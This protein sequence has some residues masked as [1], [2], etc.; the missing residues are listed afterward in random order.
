[1]KVELSPVT[2]L[3][4]RVGACISCEVLR[5]VKFT[6]SGTTMNLHRVLFLLAVTSTIGYGQLSYSSFSGFTISRSAL[7]FGAGEQGVALDG[8]LATMQYN[9][10]AIASL[11]I[12]SF[13]SGKRDAFIID[14]AYALSW[15]RFGFH[16]N[17]IGTFALEYSQFDLGEVVF[18]T[19]ADNPDGYISSTIHAI[20]H[21]YALSYA[22]SITR[23]IT[24]GGTIRYIHS[25]FYRTVDHIF[26]SGGVLYQPEILNKQLSIGF[27]LT[28]FGT[29]IHYSDADQ[30]DPAPAYMRLGVAASPVS[31]DNQKLT[32]LFE[33]SRLIA[34]I[35][36]N[37]DGKS[38]FSALFSSFKYWPHDI[39]GHGGLIYSFTDIALTGSLHFH[40]Q[41]AFGVSDQTMNSFR[42]N[43]MTASWA[44]GFTAGRFTLD[45]GAASVWQYISGN[46][47]D[48]FFQKTIPDEELELKIS[49]SPAMV[50]PES[51]ED[52][53]T[54]L[55]AGI[56]ALSP[57]GHLKEYYA[58]NGIAYSIELAHYT[59]PSTAIVSSLS[60]EDN[61]TGGLMNMFDADG[62]WRTFMVSMMYRHDF[63][64]QWFPIYFQAGPSLFRWS[65]IP[66]SSYLQVS[67]RYKYFGGITAG[68]GIPIVFNKI[69]IVPNLNFISM[70]ADVSGSAPR[71]GGYNQWSFCIRLG[72]E[73]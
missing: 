4:W 8:G 12:F 1:M 18:T 40:Q 44:M 36:D 9:P 70:F 64:A 23:S 52:N 54:T 62:K 32:F 49:Y 28:D 66:S 41:L 38:S 24:L 59:S 22:A 45:F 10:A 2:L 29:P 69:I 37:H 14:P 51:R 58:G 43:Q 26:F 48:S 61:K 15:Y 25:K 71:L 6:L 21:S 42:N 13:E 50:I 30:G 16:L 11:S 65:Y 27:S 20:E 55:S 56:G 33:G 3:K 39:K 47:R 57:I 46:G 17:D 7:T 63:S 73:L 67:P 60:F 72:T 53:K 68:V 5:N 19:I 31:S 34:D 35:D